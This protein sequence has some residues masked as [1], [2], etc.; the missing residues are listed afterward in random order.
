MLN[1]GWLRGDQANEPKKQ[2]DAGLLHAPC[3]IGQA[4]Q[5]LEKPTPHGSAH[6][7]HFEQTVKSVLLSSK[8]RVN[9]EATLRSP[10]SLVGAGN[11][12]VE[13]CLILSRNVSFAC[14]QSTKTIDL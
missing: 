14:A 12:G 10:R 1:C 4:E 5:A 6:P 11:S 13:G 8:E 7:G 9:C 3:N 2:P